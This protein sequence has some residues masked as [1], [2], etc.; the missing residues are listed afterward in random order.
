MTWQGFADEYAPAGAIR[1]GSFSMKTGRDDMVTCRATIAVAD[2]IMSLQARAAGPIG[3]MTSMLYEVGAPIQI[4]S[5]HQREV[6]GTVTTFLL[7]EGDDR[8]CWAYGNGATGDEANVNALIAGAN[9]LQ[10]PIS[11]VGRGR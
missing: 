9:R 1:L 10:A 4:V 11:S 3:A 2:R 7:C 8:Q 6:D 5:L